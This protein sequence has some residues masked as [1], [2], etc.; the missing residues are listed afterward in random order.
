[1]SATTSAD[2]DCWRHVHG[3]ARSSRSSFYWAMR[4]MPSWRRAAM[5]AIYAFCR[6]LD[7]IADGDAT[8]AERASGLDAWR[9]EVERIWNGEAT[10][11]TGRALL[12]VRR[13]FPIA[14][15]DL[16]AVID[17]VATDATGIVLAPS[18]AE[19][20]LY[21][22]RVASAVGRLSVAV[23]GE[24]GDAGHDLAAHLGRA[25]QLTNIL[26]DVDE[27]AA[28]GRLYVPEEMLAEAGVRSRDPA[29]VVRD[30]VLPRA[31]VALA[32]K[33]RTHFDAA[34]EAL[35]RCERHRVRPAAVMM[36]SYR[37]LLDRMERRGWQHRSPRMRLGRLEKLL[38]GLRHGVL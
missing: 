22:D 10:T 25:L 21:C 9:I 12:E 24:H 6:E 33:A 13:D 18:L 35:A 31:C 2:V 36:V 16:L 23:F 34:A 7:D 11:P 26:R 20:D 3:V 1:M 38:I 28:I 37:T 19:L 29:A 27:D 17:G 5:F 15:D 8:A 14:R 4:L 30:P 32:R